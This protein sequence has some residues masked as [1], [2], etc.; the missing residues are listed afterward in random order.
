MKK[1]LI[2]LFTF[3]LVMP[4]LMAATGGELTTGDITEHFAT[5]SGIVALTV[6]FTEIIK[7]WLG[8]YDNFARAVS[9]ITGFIVSYA[10][11]LMNAGLLDN[12]QWWQVL[13]Y[14]FGASLAANGLFSIPVVK[15]IIKSIL[16]MIK[17]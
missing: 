8:A 10:G 16:Y 5:V 14:G 13:I 12:L 11:W 3:F 2:A 4:T 15:S 7:R 6:T 1:L 9:W 17:K